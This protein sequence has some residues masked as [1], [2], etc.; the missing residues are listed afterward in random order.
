MMESDKDLGLYDETEHLLSSETNKKK[1]LESIKQETLEEA[2]EKYSEY[3]ED[4][5]N[6]NTYEHGFKD[7]AKCQQE[8]MYSEEEVFI[9]LAKMADTIFR[10]PKRFTNSREWFEKHKKK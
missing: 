8:I 1:L 2:F 5:E 6:K 3:L 10:A 7:G 9:L 4:Y